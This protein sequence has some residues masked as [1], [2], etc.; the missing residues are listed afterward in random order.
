MWDAEDRYGFRT[1][2]QFGRGQITVD[3]EMGQ[4]LYNLACDGKYHRFLEVG[5]WNGL[6]STKCFY[7]GFKERERRIRSGVVDDKAYFLD[8]LE[9]NRD[10][11]DYAFHYYDRVPQIQVRHARVVETYPSWNEVARTLHIHDPDE[12][13][14]LKR[15]YETDMLNVHSCGVFTPLHAYPEKETCY[16]V[17]LLDGSELLSYWEYSRIRDWTTVLVLDDCASLKNQKVYDELMDSPDWTVMTENLR[18]RNGFAAF[19][20]RQDVRTYTVGV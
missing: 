5:T 10:K 17:V 2:T 19:T 14:T 20:R 4:F 6:G 12:V 15:Y 7:E 1:E 16:D 18:E 11:W 8:S 3:T 13:A 9:V